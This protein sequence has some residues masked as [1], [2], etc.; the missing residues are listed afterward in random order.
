MSRRTK[1]ALILIALLVLW[2]F[3]GLIDNYY[4]VY[5]SLGNQSETLSGRLGIWAVVL[6][7]AVQEPW[8]GHGFHSFRNVIPPFGEF[9]AWHAHNELLQQF[10]IYGVVGIILFVGIYGSFYRQ[11][12]CLSSRST[13]ALFM[14]LLLFIVIR[15]L[16]DTENFDL[17]FPLW[18]ITL[19]SLTLARSEGLH[20]DR[21][22]GQAGSPSQ[23][24]QQGAKQRSSLKAYQS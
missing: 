18:A 1:I 10:Y 17:S 8:I 7:R 20:L 6:D 15:G 16:A 11:V 14:G 3:W 23:L 4:E 22:F 2:A 12:R 24:H 19:T 13:K 9:E 5:T 21:P